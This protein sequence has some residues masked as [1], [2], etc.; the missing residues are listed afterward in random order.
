MISESCVYW[1]LKLDSIVS[2][3]KS[4][5][6]FAGMLAF[7][8][9]VYSM[10]LSFEYSHFFASA[11]KYFFVSLAV[12]II[13]FIPATLLPTTK[14]MAMIKIIPAI[15]SSEFTTEMSGDAKEIYQLGISAI[16][17]K[18]QQYKTVDKNG[19]AGADR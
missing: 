9:L 8:M 7:V 14:E 11:K 1:V 18:L 10:I 16:K 13:L 19:K 3:F 12:S 4:A 17:E 6:M 2:F 5:G 15:S